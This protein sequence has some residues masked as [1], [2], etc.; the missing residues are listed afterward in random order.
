MQSRLQN[1]A[2]AAELLHDHLPAF[3]CH[4]TLTSE[5]L[6]KGKLKRR[7]DAAGELRVQP[8]QDGKFDERFQASEVDGKPHVGSIHVPIFVSGGFKN[9]LDLF[10]PEDQKC[11]TYKLSSSRLDFRSP[12]FAEGELC[13]QR[14]GITG[15]AQFDEDGNLDHIELRVEEA[16][17]VERNVVPFGALDLSRVDLGGTTYLLSTHVIAERPRDKSVFR[18]EATYS[19]CRLYQVTVKI[20]PA[21]PAPEDSAK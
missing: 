9:A 4:E 19:N 12:L 3:A 10:M 21:A 11:F 1:L 5:E 14:T 8:A 15:F 13:S 2:Q 16:R 18:W 20:G 6:R 17:A 7:V